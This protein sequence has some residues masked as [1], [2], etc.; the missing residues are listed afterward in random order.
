MATVITT[1]G[2]Q[3]PEAVRPPGALPAWTLP[4]ALLLVLIMINPRLYVGG[5]G[6]DWHYLQAA[7]CAAGHGLCLP[8]DHWSA[9]FPLVLPAGAALAVLGEGEWALALV[10][11]LYAAAAILLFVANVERRYDRPAAMLA[12]AALALTPLFPLSALR[13]GVDFPEF[14]WTMAGLLAIQKA[15][16]RKDARWAALAG[17]ALAMAMMSRASTA[18][19]LAVLAL[20]WLLLDRRRKLLALPFAAGFTA[21]LGGEALAYAA[22]TGD[23]FFGW[24]LSLNHGRI[25]TTELPESVDLSR[26]PILNLDFISNWR[27]SM[28]IHVHWTIDPMLNLLANPLGGLTLC[29]A[30]GVGLVRGGDWRRDRWLPLL[31]AAA[32]LHFVLLTY[33]L[34]VDPKPRMFLFG[35]AVAAATLGV[36]GVRAWR[37]GGRLIVAV[38]AVLLAGRA[39]LV[40]Y[41]QPN[42]ARVRAV[43]AEWIAAAPQESLAADEWTRRT[44]ALVP[45]AQSLPVV[46]Q[47]P[48]RLRLTLAPTPCTGTVLR[49]RRFERAEWRL[50]AW[51]RAHALLLRPQ[52]PLRLC[53]VRP[54][55]RSAGG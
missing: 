27:R 39:V 50:V 46:E 34:A 42:L 30:L 51:L 7:R 9:R 5:G 52:V 12:G 26:S 3:R 47:A 16:E 36:L 54:G 21:L 40:V 23:P 14:A 15:L 4:L 8:G 13:L 53:L 49:E 44:I 18:A 35:H 32:L 55:P 37:G 2:K 45:A 1:A 28:G 25:P 38:L 43:A 33:A 17:A 10:P 22:A 29:G 6:D 11:L 31:A 24:K 48:Y 41:D 19:L 20:G